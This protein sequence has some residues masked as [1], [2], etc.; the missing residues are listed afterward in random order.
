MTKDYVNE[1]L[2]WCKQVQSKN[3]SNQLREFINHLNQLQKLDYLDQKTLH[4]ID[5]E[6]KRIY[7]DKKENSEGGISQHQLPPLPYAYNALEPVISERIMYLHHT[8]HHLSYVKGLNK[9]EKELAQARK[10]SN[11][12]LIKHWERELAFHGSGHYLHTVFW[13][14][15]S[16]NGGGKPDGK[17]LQQIERD[18]SSFE[19]FKEHFSE[20]AKNVEGVGWAIL[21]WS[22]RA[23]RLEILQAEKHQNL[24]QWD[25]IP[26]LALDVWEH[27]YYLQYE[28]NRAKYVKEWWKIV[29]WPYVNSRYT[30]AMKVKW[31][32]F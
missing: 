14:V 15:M 3:D 10:N 31:E 22:P 27:A 23:H 19:K 26:L 18:F 28:N 6:A 13:N 9:A 20:A 7:F 16:P 4:D 2:R 24:T 8:K 11:Y 21:V 12:S 17:L 30:K 32:K 29:N 25:T 5:L 1:M